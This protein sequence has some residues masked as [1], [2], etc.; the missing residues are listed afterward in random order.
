[1]SNVKF[2]AFHRPSLRSG[3]Y[4][5]EVSEKITIASPPVGTTETNTELSKTTRYFSV[6]GERYGLKPED[7]VAV[8]PPEGSFGDLF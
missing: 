2:H 7:V 8:F 3:N 4:K 6:A 1:M 5:I